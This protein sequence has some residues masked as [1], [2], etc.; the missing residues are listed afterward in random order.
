MILVLTDGVLNRKEG[1]DQE[2]IQLRYTFRSKTPKGK[3]DAI[4]AT[5]PR[6]N[7]TS[8]KPNGQFLS[9]KLAK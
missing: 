7:T 6:Q 5:A 4:K 1:N 8:R 9:Q 2:S 3:K